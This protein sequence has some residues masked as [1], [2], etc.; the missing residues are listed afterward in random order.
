MKVFI[1]EKGTIDEI[2]NT[3]FCPIN[4]LGVYLIFEIFRWAFIGEGR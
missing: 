3:V 4:D 2:K 1:S